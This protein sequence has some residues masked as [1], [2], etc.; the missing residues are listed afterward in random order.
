MDAPYERRVS[1]NFR[2]LKSWAINTTIRSAEFIGMWEGESDVV[3]RIITP[4]YRLAATAA[5]DPRQ[6]GEGRH[7]GQHFH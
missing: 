3:A 4:D 2:H 7:L 1:N 5:G 6:R